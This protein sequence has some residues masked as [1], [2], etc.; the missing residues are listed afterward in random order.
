MSPSN[1]STKIE[2]L[3]LL[4]GIAYTMHAEKGS[5]KLC[6]IHSSTSCVDLLQLPDCSLQGNSI[7]VNIFTM[8]KP[9]NKTKNP[10]FTYREQSFQ[11]FEQAYKR[12]IFAIR[13]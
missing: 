11:E 6:K 10:F 1:T 7:N 3:H 13:L 2:I 12:T 4:H 8:S 9:F 5:N